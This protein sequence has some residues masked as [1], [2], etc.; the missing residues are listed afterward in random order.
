ML[1]HHRHRNETRRVHIRWSYPI[2]HQLVRSLINKFNI[3]NPQGTHI[4][5]TICCY[6]IGIDFYESRPLSQDYTYWV[7]S[8]EALRVPEGAF[9]YSWSWYCYSDPSRTSSQEDT[10][11]LFP[12]NNKAQNTVL[13]MIEQSLQVIHNEGI[14]LILDLSFT[15]WISWKSYFNLFVYKACV[16]KNKFINILSTSQSLLINEIL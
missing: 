11:L 8:K 1:F 13:K 15:I 16:L 6:A 2:K 7:P 5:N 12:L 9:T 3:T 4:S 10:I 14:W